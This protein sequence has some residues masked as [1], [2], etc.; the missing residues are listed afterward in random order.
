MFKMLMLS[1]QV[2]CILFVNMYIIMINVYWICE[3]L[4]NG[5]WL[6]KIS[7]YNGTDWAKE[8]KNL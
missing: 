6:L 4:K 3:N 7:L 5:W 1:G 2:N 8:K